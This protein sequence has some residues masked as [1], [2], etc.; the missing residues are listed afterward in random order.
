MHIYA[1][2]NNHLA[3]FNTWFYCVVCIHAI[4]TRFSRHLVPTCLAVIKQLSFYSS[5][6]QEA[7]EEDNNQPKANDHGSD[8][9]NFEGSEWDLIRSNGDHP[10]PNHKADQLDQ[11]MDT[12][13]LIKGKSE[14]YEEKFPFFRAGSCSLH[15][16]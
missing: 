12:E 10:M 13:E 11:E 7:I 1:I 3:Q 8:M 2:N 5:L 14:I 15:H 16:R 6:H 4:C 9:P